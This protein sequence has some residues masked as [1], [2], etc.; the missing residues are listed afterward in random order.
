MEK[1]HLSDL[2]GLS[3]ES[4]ISKKIDFDTVLGSFAMKKARKA[5]LFC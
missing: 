4:D 3:I 1:G 2:V 5:I